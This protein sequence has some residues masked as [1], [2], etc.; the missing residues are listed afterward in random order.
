[1]TYE[2]P[3]L[4]GKAGAWPWIPKWFEPLSRVTPRRLKPGLHTPCQAVVL[5]NDARE[6]GFQAG[7]ILA[8]IVFLQ[9]ELAAARAHL[10]RQRLVS[11]EMLDSCRK[12]RAVHMGRE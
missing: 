2:V 5:L 6:H 4:A 9:C 12:L 3:A 10:A 7:D 8:E 1:M 11:Q